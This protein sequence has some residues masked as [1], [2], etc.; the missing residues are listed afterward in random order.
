MVVL[1]AVIGCGTPD[2]GTAGPGF[3][4]PVEVSADRLEGSFVVIRTSGTPPAPVGVTLTIQHGR[5]STTGACPCGIADLT[6]R[7]G[8]LVVEFVESSAIGC[9]SGA[10][11]TVWDQFFLPFLTAD[12]AVAQPQ[13]RREGAADRRHDVGL[14]IAGGHRPHL[15]GA[16]RWC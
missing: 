5:I 4:A 13:R 8:R 9:E 12:P 10:P 2:A 16:G 7:D 3:P 15:V 1:V 6:V 14:E 11:T